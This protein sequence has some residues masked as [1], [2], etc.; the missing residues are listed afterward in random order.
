LQFS[1]AFAVASRLAFATAMLMFALIAI[2]AA[3]RVTGSGLSCPDWPLCE[4][5][6]IPRFEYHVMI[7]WFH[8][9]VALLV[10]LMLLATAGWTWAHRE[11][12]ARLG[13]LAAGAVGLYLVQALLGALTVWKLL[14]PTMVSSHLAVGTLLFATLLT[15]GLIAQGENESEPAVSALMARP[16]GLLPLAALATAWTWLQI[17]IGGMVSSTHAGLACPDWPLCGGQWWPPMQGLVGLHMTHRLSGYGLLLTHAATALL[18]R[19]AG[20]SRIGTTAALAFGQTLVQIGIGVANVLL[21]L[22][23]WLS[24]LHLATAAAILALSVMTLFRV[25]RLPAAQ[26]QVAMAE[27]R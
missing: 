16:I 13:L 21:A 3:V 17:V 20:D 19:R 7:E 10:G 18:A 12:R 25:S 23:S 22:P 14:S 1:R 11:T 6:L 5:R 2:G 27:A 26:G 15:L 4:G 24:V 8:R 9:L